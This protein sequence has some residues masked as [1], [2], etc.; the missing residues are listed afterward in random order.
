MCRDELVDAMYRPW[1]AV[2]IQPEVAEKATPP[3]LPGM[4]STPFEVRFLVNT[5]A[6][7]AR[8]L[9]R[10]TFSHTPPPF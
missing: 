5:A 7:T 1:Q 6:R 8:W 3:V 2:N 10:S 4:S 9:L